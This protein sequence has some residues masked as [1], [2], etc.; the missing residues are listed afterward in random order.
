MAAIEG[1]ERGLRV[2]LLHPGKHIGGVTTGGLGMTDIGNK[3]AIGG[4]SLEFYQRVGQACGMDIA[5]R[6][7]PHVAMS[8]FHEW[9]A[10]VELDTI[11]GAYIEAAQVVDGRLVALT[12]V[13][14]LTVKASVFIDTSYEGDLMARAGVSYTVGREDNSRYDET[15]NGAQIREHHQF[16]APVDPYVV[17]G[18]PSS[19][20]LPGIEEAADYVQGEGDHR[21][22]AYNF[23]MCLTQ[24]KDIRLAF[25]KPRD[26]R[27]EQYILLKRWLDTG[28]NEAF[29]KFDLLINGKTDTNN[30]GAVSTD[31]IGANHHYTEASY[32]ERE[33]IFQAHVSYQQGLMWCLANDKDIPAAIREPMRTWGLC[34]DEFGS[35]GGWPHAL[36]VRESRRMVS[37]LVM[38]EHHCMK[39][40]FVDDS[41]GLAA[42]NMDSHN[43]RRLVRQ[44]RVVNE[45]DVQV[46][47]P[48]PYE[49]SYRSIVPKAGECS[50]LLVPFCLSASHIA[51]GSIRMEPV[52][53]GLSQAATIA[54]VIALDDGCQV[55]EVSYESLELELL[56]A[57]LIPHFRE[58]KPQPV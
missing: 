5:W 52:F 45:G 16:L 6:F 18:V 51:F 41:I 1:V 32:A 15:L 28:W 22:Q 29:E 30:H 50:N 31:Y 26:Y 58:I 33:D 55:Q 11:T 37:D 49:V 9:L 4:K 20:L 2:A 54:A 56:S 47:V 57:G 46:C 8:V 23:R 7:E 24:R 34:A 17:P 39:N 12:T 27:S 19:G 35:T 53:M 14:G 13:S 36:Y 42:Y 40:A 3:Y 38:T 25:P 48:G 44:G 21:V 10:Q 43:C